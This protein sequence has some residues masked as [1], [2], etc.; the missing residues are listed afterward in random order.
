MIRYLKNIRFSAKVFVRCY[1]T[2]KLFRYYYQRHQLENTRKIQ[3]KLHIFFILYRF[4]FSHTTHS[5]YCKM[6]RKKPSVK[7]SSI[8]IIKRNK[9][10]FSFINHLFNHFPP[11]ATYPTIKKKYFNLSDQFND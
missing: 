7:W 3:L 8:I 1:I 9:H 5:F 10:L 4:I 2:F 6:K 11:T